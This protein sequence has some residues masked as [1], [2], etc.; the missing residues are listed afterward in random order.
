MVR[1][2]GGPKATTHPSLNRLKLMTTATV[3]VRDETSIRQYCRGTVPLSGRLE[4]WMTD[5]IGGG[6]DIDVF[7]LIERYGSPI[8]L[9]NPARMT[10]SAKRLKSVA[11]KHGIDFEVYFARKANKS[12]ALVDAARDLAIGIDTASEPE[13]VQVLDRGHPAEKTICTAAVKSD[14]LIRRCVN[15]GVPIA[16]DNFDELHLVS[17]VAESMGRPADIAIRTSGFYWHESKLPSRFGIDI[18][19]MDRV[20]AELTDHPHVRLVGLHFHLDG[21]DATQRVAAIGQLLP[22]VDRLRAAGHGIAFVDIGGG[23]PMSYLDDGEQWNLFWRAADDALLNRSE[24]I[25]YRNHGFGRIAH[26]GQIVGRANLYPYHQTPVAA[27]WLDGVL[28]ADLPDHTGVATTVADGLRNRGIELRCEPGRS[29]LDGVG[30][31]V[32]RVEHVKQ[33]AAGETLAG[34]AM[35]RT[36]CRTTVDDFL[37]D[38]VLIRRDDDGDDGDDGDAASGYLTGAYCTE[39]EL[40]SLR[41]MEFP[42]GIA[43]GDLIVMVNTAGYLMHFLESRSH[44]FP[45]AKNLVVDDT[46]G[47]ISLDPIDE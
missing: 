17:S 23:L 2:I 15:G 13:L 4:P 19:Q 31:T 34:L 10:A 37:V 3:A 45:L 22:W 29:L 30:L 12:I 25:T 5:L 16:V 9:L 38:P 14:S 39:S 40:I 32:A 26:D 33:N 1:T 11:A 43:R 47:A 20:A 35:N 24:P 18:D 8:N 41:K 21:Y 36:Q 28:G 42:R 7:E 27:E 46:L 6:S 44:Q